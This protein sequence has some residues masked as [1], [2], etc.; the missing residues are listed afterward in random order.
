LAVLNFAVYIA[1]TKVTCPL[2]FRVYAPLMT[3]NSSELRADISGIPTC[4]G[5]SFC[6]EDWHNCSEDWHNCS[7]DWHYCWVQGAGKVSLNMLFQN[8]SV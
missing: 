6:S 8:N 2:P 7:E 4:Y 3:A 5:F 1:S